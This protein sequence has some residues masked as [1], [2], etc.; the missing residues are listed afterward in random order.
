MPVNCLMAMFSSIPCWRVQYSQINFIPREII[1]ELWNEGLVKISRKVSGLVSVALWFHRTATILQHWCVFDKR[2]SDLSLDQK[3]SADHF[4]AYPVNSPQR[5][6]RFCK[7]FPRVL[8]SISSD[9]AKY[10]LGFAK[11][12]KADLPEIVKSLKLPPSSICQLCHRLKKWWNS[13]TNYER[14]GYL[15]NGR[16]EKKTTGYSPDVLPAR[17]SAQRVGFFNVGSGRVG[18]SKNMIGYYRVSFFLSGISGYFG[19][20]RVCRVFSGISGFTHIY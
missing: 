19:Y 4:F 13:G 17:V 3:P 7:I 16:E 2:I 18:V 1:V 8:Q 11:Y 20:F 10:F 5:Y 6:G 12:F 15:C 9:F 14:L